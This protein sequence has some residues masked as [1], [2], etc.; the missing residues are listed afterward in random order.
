MSDFPNPTGPGR[1][2]AR[3]LM[4]LSDLDEA[5]TLEA[6]LVE[7]RCE[8]ERT[9]VA[10]ARAVLGAEPWTAVL[11]DADEYVLI[12]SPANGMGVKRSGDLRH[13]RDVGKSITLGQRDWPWAETRLTAGFGL[14]STDLR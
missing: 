11:T 5:Q 10:G 9:D 1:P 3:V 14:F 2:A 13:W 6:A 8:V 4:A 12:H 7:A